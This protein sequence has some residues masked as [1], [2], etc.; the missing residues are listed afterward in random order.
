M[1]SLVFAG[2]GERDD[3]NILP[4][5]YSYSYCSE[6][7]A[8]GLSAT[9]AYLA[10]HPQVQQKAFEEIAR[11]FTDNNPAVIYASS[12]T[13]RLAMLRVEQLKLPG[14]YRCQ[15]IAVHILLLSRGLKACS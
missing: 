7:T 15:S 6:S 8:S 9:F 4:A 1:L 5:S 2:H 13:L 3:F 14:G 10:V 11:A 12:K